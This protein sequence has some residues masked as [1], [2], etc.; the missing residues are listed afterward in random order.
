[1]VCCKVK[2]DENGNLFHIHFPINYVKSLILEFRNLLL[3]LLI[4]R[5]SFVQ[6]CAYSAYTSIVRWK[7]KK[8]GRKRN[9]SLWLNLIFIMVYFIEFYILFIQRYVQRERDK[10]H[11]FGFNYKRFFL[12]TLELH[13]TFFYCFFIWNKNMSSTCWL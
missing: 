9:F 5:L 6:I 2:T 3:W 4:Q 13:A 8:D 12:I 1:M 7:K 10:I 11:K